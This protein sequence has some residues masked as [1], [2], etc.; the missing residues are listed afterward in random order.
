VTACLHIGAKA[1]ARLTPSDA[2]IIV[3]SPS[4]RQAREQQVSVIPA[5]EFSCLAR[6]EIHLKLLGYESRLIVAGRSASEA[7]DFLKRDYIGVK[8]AQHFDY[9]GGIGFSVETFASV[10]VIS[11][12]PNMFHQ[13][14]LLPFKFTV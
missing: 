6:K 13:V 1:S 11:G 8:F 12:Y 7:Q 4:H 3:E 10:N 2:E 5:V 14:E 9:A